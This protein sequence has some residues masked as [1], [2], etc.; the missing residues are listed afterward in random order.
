MAAG[1]SLMGGSGS[2]GM[3]MM[4][5]MHMGDSE[6]IVFGAWTTHSPG[7]MFGACVC[8]ILISVARHYIM[9]WR[10]RVASFMGRDNSAAELLARG[11]AREVRDTLRAYGVVCVLCGSRGCACGGGGS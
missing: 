3:M 10:A 2:M 1:R 9:C 7:T 8:V 6:T 11:S 4:G 5:P